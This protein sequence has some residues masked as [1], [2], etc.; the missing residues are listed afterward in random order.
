MS[1]IVNSFDVLKRGYYII[2]SNSLDELS[3]RNNDILNELTGGNNES[4]RY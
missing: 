1:K 4:I 2:E 3:K